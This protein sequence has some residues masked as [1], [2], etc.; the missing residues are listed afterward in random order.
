MKTPHQTTVESLE[1]SSHSTNPVYLIKGDIS[2]IQD[3]IFNVNSKGAARS[4][5]GRSFF[6]K[7]LLE[8]VMQ[9]VFDTFRIAVENQEDAKISTSGGNFILQLNTENPD[10]IDDIQLEISKSLKYSGLNM[11]LTCVEMQESYQNTLEVL[12]QKTRQRKFGLLTKYNNFFDPFDRIE[13]SNIN[14]LSNNRTRENTK[15]HG[16]TDELKIKDNSL[17]INIDPSASSQFKISRNQIEILGYKVSFGKGGI[18]VSNFLEIVF[19]LKEEG[20]YKKNDNLL[21][22]ED[23]SA[24]KYF[25]QHFDRYDRNSKRWIYIGKRGIDKLGILA[26]DVDNLGNAVENVSSPKEHKRFDK[27]LQKFFNHKLREIIT[28]KYFNQVYTVTAGGDD[29]FF[30]GKWN[31]MI[32]LAIEINTA[33]ETEFKERELSISAGLVIVDSKFPVVRFAQMAEDALKNAKYTYEK[34][35]NISLFGEVLD[36]DILKRE[37]TNLRNDFNRKARNLISSGLLAKARHTA[38]NIADDKGVKLSDFWIMSY[39]MRNIR[40]EKH[41]GLLKEHQNL[42][43][44]ST[45]QKSK[46]LAKNYRLIFPIAARLA[47][48]DNR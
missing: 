17:L 11:M 13:I 24:G 46:Q 35:G 15:W 4:L 42:L 9:K 33:F 10:L 30:V 41:G 44:L 48:L 28:Q 22:F 40:G 29:S 39:Y 12:H 19:P 1:N 26:M 2:G 20:T 8:V 34:K 3:F 43:T 16:I 27:Q 21:K 47:E 36:W 37:V 38:I 7:I 23:L 31:T 6:I 45:T 25:N 14:G 18:S 5:K 32:D